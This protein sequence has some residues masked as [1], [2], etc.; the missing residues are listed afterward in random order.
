MEQIKQSETSKIEIKHINQSFLDLKEQMKEGFSGVHNRLD[1]MNGKV[2]ENTE[3]RVKSER[4][5]EMVEHLGIQFNELYGKTMR[6]YLRIEMKTKLIWG[7][8]GVFGTSLISIITAIII[9]KV[10]KT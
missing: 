1:I 10:T 7:L 8:F 5:P 9:F 6:G 2:A 3:F 4:L